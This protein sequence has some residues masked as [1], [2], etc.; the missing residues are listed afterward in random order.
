MTAAAT[1]RPRILQALPGPAA[2]IATG[3]IASAA[4]FGRPARLG[5]RLP[6]PGGVV[7]HRHSH[8]AAL[9]LVSAGDM[10]AAARLAELWWIPGDIAVASFRNGYIGGTCYAQ[11]RDLAATS[12][13]RHPFGHRPGHRVSAAVVAATAMR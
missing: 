8:R 12:R 1:L 10:A 5:D 4:V 7:R 9:R 3:F 11:G 6:R 13:P 2:T